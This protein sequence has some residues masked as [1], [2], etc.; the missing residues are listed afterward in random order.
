M[1]MRVVEVLHALKVA[2]TQKPAPE[3]IQA[4]SRHAALNL[5]L[6]QAQLAQA[7][8]LRGGPWVRRPL[9]ELQ[10]AA[11]SVVFAALPPTHHT[12]KEMAGMMPYSHR[13][14]YKFGRG[15]PNPESP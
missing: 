8:G 12:A 14:Y 2:L 15:G 10:D 9:E 6:A 1:G 5:G 4:W 7:V 13:A 3:H 11:A